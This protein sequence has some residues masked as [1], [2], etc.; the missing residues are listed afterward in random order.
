MLDF[1]IST[2]NL[3][4]E[5]MRLRSRIVLEGSAGQQG[6]CFHFGSTA[7]SAVLLF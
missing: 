3:G 1:A 2:E 4:V 5:L 6:P 7:R